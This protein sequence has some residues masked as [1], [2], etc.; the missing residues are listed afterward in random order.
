MIP[1]NL[2]ILL[3]LIGIVVLVKVI[4]WTIVVHSVNMKLY[5][6]LGEEAVKWIL[7]DRNNVSPEIK[8]FNFNFGSSD[9]RLAIVSMLS[10][11]KNLPK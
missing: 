9:L 4:H 5:D 11:F 10:I 3:S 1:S 8:S 7:E 2:I 6:S